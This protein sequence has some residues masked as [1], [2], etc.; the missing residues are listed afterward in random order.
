M[1]MEVFQTITRSPGRATGRLE[2]GPQAL[3]K[4]VPS[5]AQKGETEIRVTRQQY[6]CL[7]KVP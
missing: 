5:T 4:S 3:F 2:S 6:Y 1:P 7:Q